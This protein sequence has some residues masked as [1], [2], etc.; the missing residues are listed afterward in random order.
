MNYFS[1]E[2]Q[3]DLTHC[4]ILIN[5]HHVI[6]SNVS[7]IHVQHLPITHVGA[8]YDILKLHWCITVSQILYLTRYNI[9]YCI[10]CS[11]VTL[12]LYFYMH[13]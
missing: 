6:E 5:L 4:S 10:F 2:T 3:Y 1:I 9:K 7:I 8:F 13:H 12:H 11:L